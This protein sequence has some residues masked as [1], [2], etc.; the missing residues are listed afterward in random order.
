MAATSLLARLGLR[1]ATLGSAASLAIAAPIAEGDVSQDA[2]THASRTGWFFPTSTSIGF[3]ADG[4]E[5]VRF[6]E[7]GSVQ[8]GGTF[9]AEAGIGNLSISGGRLLVKDDAVVTTVPSSSVHVIRNGPSGIRMDSYNATASASPDLIMY[10]SRGTD[11]IP[12]AVLN[13]DVLGSISVFGRGATAFST[14]A[15]A[16]IQFVARD[17]WTGTSQGTTIRFS[18]TNV[19]SVTTSE[20]MRIWQD[21]GVQV[22]DTFTTSPGAGNLSAAELHSDRLYYSRTTAT[23]GYQ[24]GLGGGYISSVWNGSSYVSSVDMYWHVGMNRALLQLST[25]GVFRLQP[26]SLPSNPE[27]GS[28]ALDSD[29]GNTLKWYDGTVWRTAGVYTAPGVLTDAATIN[30]TVNA[31]DNHTLLLTTAVGATRLLATPTNLVAGMRWVIR[32]KQP[33]V[34]GPCAL[35]FSS[36]Y[37]FPYG[38]TPLL[39]TTPDSIDT[40]S[41]YYDGTVILAQVV[42][43]YGTV[44]SVAVSGSSLSIT[45]P[46]NLPN[47]AVSGNLLLSDQYTVAVD[48]TAGPV[49]ITLPS[50]VTTAHRGRVYN[51]KKTDASANAVTIVRSGADLIDGATSVALTVQYQTRTVH[52]RTAG[53]VWDVI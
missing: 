34:G 31:L 15:R 40:I 36:D 26:N 30:Y 20:R 39:S 1:V 21:G 53:G 13:A 51:I 38:I 25:L 12:S 48:A 14:S 7:D 19:S 35:T 8:I 49:T 9:T 17:N 45:G 24:E 23:A 44:A 50:T 52:S 18:T 29:F 43:S 10:R 11:A 3:V 37:K 2:H 42:N 4:A 5:R 47:V 33:A 27:T 32:A 41:C 28:I 46:V 22:G 16:S 6:W